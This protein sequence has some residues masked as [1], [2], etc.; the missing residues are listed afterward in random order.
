MLRMPHYA[1]SLCVHRAIALYCH[2]RQWHSQS[3]LLILRSRDFEGEQKLHIKKN[4][5]TFIQS[6][7]FFLQLLFLNQKQ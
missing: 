4:I 1:P 6:G 5:N 7:V 2:P 3:R